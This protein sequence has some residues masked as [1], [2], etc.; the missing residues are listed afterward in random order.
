MVSARCDEGGVVLPHI[1]LVSVDHQDYRAFDNDH[2]FLCVVEVDA[3]GRAS[4]EGG[5]TAGNLS[6]AI[7]FGYTAGYRDTWS[8]LQAFDYLSSDDSW[9]WYLNSLLWID[10]VLGQEFSHDFAGRFPIGH[11]VQ[12]DGVAH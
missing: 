7:L 9:L 4:L 8:P 3:V 6:S 1:V 12:N 2:R 11:V 10:L 5:D